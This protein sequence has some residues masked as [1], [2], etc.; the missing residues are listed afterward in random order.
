MTRNRVAPGTI[1]ATLIIF[2]VV[3]GTLEVF[4]YTQKSA[5]ID[6]PIHLATGYPAIR[7]PGCVIRGSSPPRLSC[8]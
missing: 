6:E 4:A 5:T 2:A 7:F 3:F 8:Q 1:A